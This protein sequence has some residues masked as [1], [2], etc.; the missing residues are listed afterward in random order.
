MAELRAKMG[1]VE[2][3]LEEKTAEAGRWG[4]AL[5][6]A[7]VGTPDELRK[8]AEAHRRVVEELEERGGGG[9]GGGG[10]GGGAV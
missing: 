8:L 4:A 10:A 5:R 1:K 7:E 9:G 6:E 3:A 2:V